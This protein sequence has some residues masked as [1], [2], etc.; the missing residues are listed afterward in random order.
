MK[1]Y[2]DED[3]VNIG[4]SS[5]ISIRDLADVIAQ[6]VGFKGRFVY[7]ASMPDGTPRKLMDSSRLAALGWTAKTPL[8]DGVRQTYDWFLTDNKKRQIEVARG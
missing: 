3:H 7:D 2:S 1:N 4:V 8:V 5:D 6:V